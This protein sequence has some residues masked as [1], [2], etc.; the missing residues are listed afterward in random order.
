MVYETTPPD[1]SKL[2]FDASGM[3]LPYIVVEFS[4]MY[5]V[6][7][8]GGIVSTKYDVKG[9]YIIVSC[10]APT[11]RAARQVAGAVRSKLLGFKPTDA[12]ELVLNASGAVYTLMESKINRYVSELAFSFPVNTVW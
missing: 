7:L 5:D 4:D 10:I 8:A 6:P 3:M 12:G 11:E 9:S 2:K 1:D